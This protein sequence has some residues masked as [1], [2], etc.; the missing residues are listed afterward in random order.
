MNYT[1]LTQHWNVVEVV[2]VQKGRGKRQIERV[3]HIFY[4]GWK[5]VTINVDMFLFMKTTVTLQ[6]ITIK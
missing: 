6:G 4:E 1:I 2:V 5:L 3:C